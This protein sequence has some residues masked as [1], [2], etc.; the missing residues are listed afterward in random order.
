VAGIAI[1]GAAVAL[2]AMALF[3]RAFHSSGL[4]GPEL[5]ETVVHPWWI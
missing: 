1:I 2:V 5:E 3:T 4:E